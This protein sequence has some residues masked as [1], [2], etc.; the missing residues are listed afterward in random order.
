M[1]A[2]PGFLSRW[3]KWVQGVFSIFG[4][5]FGFVAVRYIAG[6]IAGPY[7][8]SGHTVLELSNLII[9]AEFLLVLLAFRLIVLTLRQPRTVWTI[10]LS[11]FYGLAAV[12]TVIL[13]EVIITVSITIPLTG[14][15]GGDQVDPA[16]YIAGIS[17]L[18]TAV[19]GLYGQIISARKLS[20]EMEQGQLN[21][22]G[23]QAAR[24]PRRPARK[25]AR[26]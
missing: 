13:F 2:Q 23:K 19:A 20:W 15:T 1:N 4:F 17:G 24:S 8:F 26:K 18:I 9:V 14:G 5:L 12:L 25:P 6:L 22:K 7:S 16:L 11:I 10:A 3:P 21:S